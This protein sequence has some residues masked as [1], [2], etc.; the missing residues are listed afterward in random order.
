M[1][2]LTATLSSA[3]RINIQYEDPGM[4]PPVEVRTAW[5]AGETG[6]GLDL[7]AAT[8]STTFL[9]LPVA[10]LAYPKLQYHGHLWW[11]VAADYT[12]VG[13]V[14]N[15]ELQLVLD[16]V[17]TGTAM[18]FGGAGIAAF[19]GT[20]AMLIDVKMT[21]MGSLT[22]FDKQILTAN[23]LLLDSAGTAI[24]HNETL[25]RTYTISQESDHDIGF[26][27]RKTSAVPNPNV[28]DIRSVNCTHFAPRSGS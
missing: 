25:V 1:T 17:A 20:G 12:Q 28:L 24:L 11:V 7:V 10:F 5:C 2:E 18:S 26:Q 4:Q 16:G 9:V 3:P 23:L 27:I 21:V 19:A 15:I 8:G 13:A 22:G 6:S 14:Q